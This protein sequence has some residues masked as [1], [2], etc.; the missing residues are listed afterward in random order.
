M[1]RVKK[2]SLV[3]GGV[4]LL[5]SLAACGIEASENSSTA[6]I[7]ATLSPD[8]DAGDVL[9]FGLTEPEAAIFFGS[10]FFCPGVA[11]VNW[12][13]GDNFVLIYESI[14]N[15]TID[16]ESSP[17]FHLE[18][19]QTAIDNA[20][21]VK[22]VFGVI[23]DGNKGEN[24]PDDFRLY[25]STI[26]GNGST[27]GHRVRVY[28]MDRTRMRSMSGNVLRYPD[29]GKQKDGSHLLMEVWYEYEGK[30]PGQRDFAHADAGIRVYL[31][32]ERAESK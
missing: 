8:P 26:A 24:A 6:Q 28:P 30:G 22:L 18:P 2:L 16:R 5:A 13:P 4:L 17:L 14:A 25:T 11:E 12:V 3:L 7:S 32:N 29:E 20:G 9:S 31:K 21:S 23:D 1:N 15:G 10:L 27:C 19:G